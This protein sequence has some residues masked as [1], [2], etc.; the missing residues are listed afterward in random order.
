MPSPSRRW[1]LLHLGLGLAWCAVLASR[2]P[3]GSGPGATGL[4][5]FVMLLAAGSLVLL[6]C[7]AYV[8]LFFFNVAWFLP[9]ALLPRGV[10]T[11]LLVRR[12]PGSR[13]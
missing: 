12:L 4:Q 11:E 3:G 8:P 5:V 2:A 7:S 10:V 1:L 13:P 9:L 6:A